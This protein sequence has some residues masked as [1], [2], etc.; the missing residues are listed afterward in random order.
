MYPPV[1]LLNKLEILFLDKKLSYLTFYITEE[2]FI[3]KNHTEWWI[4]GNKTMDEK[5]I[6]IPNDET[7]NYP[8]VD[9]N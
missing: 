2:G 7:Q 5:F 4:L 3:N 1:R 8:I 6:Y 9:C